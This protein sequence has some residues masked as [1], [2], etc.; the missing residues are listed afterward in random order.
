MKTE[1]KQKEVWLVNLGDYKPGST[2]Q[3]GIKPCVMLS[4]VNE[5]ELDEVLR[6]VITVAPITT[7]IKKMNMPT[8]TLITKAEGVR[9]DSCFLGEQLR[10]VLVDKCIKKLSEL[11]DDTFDRVFRCS[12]RA[13][14]DEQELKEFLQTMEAYY[15][16]ERR[17]KGKVTDI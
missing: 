3:R 14:F 6:R 7:K 11:N 1:P 10:T 12:L 9:E 15:E 13:F 17:D 4:N 16:Q 2:V 8:H 5:S